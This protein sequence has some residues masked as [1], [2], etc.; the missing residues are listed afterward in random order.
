MIRIV[1]VNGDD[2][3]GTYLCNTLKEQGDFD[4]VG[5]GKDGYEAFKLAEAHKPDILLM[6]I[7][8]NWD[9][10][11]QAASLIK[12]RYS[13]TA[14]IVCG[15]CLDDSRA[16]KAFFCGCSYLHKDVS[17]ELLHHSIRTV[18]WGGCLVSSQILTAVHQVVSMNKNAGPGPGKTA[19]PATLSSTELRIMGFIG[20]G[21]KTK[22]I[23]ARLQLGTG[24]VRNYTSSLLQ[25]MHLAD[26]TQVAVYAG[27]AGL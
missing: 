6:D 13:S 4:V 19:L 24:T 15:V 9:T 25:K 17:P 14:V 21:M 1:V 2:K 3:T 7:E 22:E 18:F 11:I 12:C 10:G 26:R 16:L 20:Q 8:A 23:A 5:Y 27:K